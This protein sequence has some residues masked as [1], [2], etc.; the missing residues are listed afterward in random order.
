MEEF[1]WHKEAKERWDERADF[2]N[3]SSEDMWERGIRKSIIPFIEKHF[4]KGSYVADLGC[5]D[6]FGTLKLHEAGYRVVGVD[7]SDEMILKAKN[8][9][10]DIAFFQGD[11]L[12]LPFQ[13]DAFTGLM[14]I[15]SLEWTEKPLKGLNEMRRVLQS[16]HLLCLGLLGP[17]A[18]PR[19]NSYRRLYNEPVICNTMMPWEFEQLAVENGWEVMDGV[20]IYRGAVDENKI[21]HYPKE[22]K[23]SLTFMWLFMLRKKEEKRL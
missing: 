7:L 9:V 22:L 17:T 10:E 13:N 8:R 5:G 11:L 21:E 12:Q 23:Q 18:H 6:G 19:K 1:N 2:W 15:N 14:A 16:G 4:P 3:Q 20:G